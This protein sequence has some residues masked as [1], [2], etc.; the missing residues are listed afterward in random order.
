MTTEL[1]ELNAVVAEFPPE[2]LRKVIEYAQLLSRPYWEL[3]GYSDEWTE[4][5]VKDYREASLRYLDQQYPEDEG[6]GD[7]AQ[8]R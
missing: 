5:D 2:K 3:P 8:P 7:L 4:D 1:V 6:Y